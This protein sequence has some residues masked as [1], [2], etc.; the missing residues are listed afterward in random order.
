AADMKGPVAA[1]MDVFVAEAHSHVGLLLTCDEESGG[2][3]GTQHVLRS[4][5]W[6]P[7]V[8]LLPDGGASMRLV[9]QQKGLLRLKL[10]AV[11]RSVH[12]ARPWQ[13]INAL[14]RAFRGYQ[15]MRRAYPPPREEADERISVT[16]TALHSVGNSPN[17]LPDVAEGVLDVRYPGDK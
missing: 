12:A 6:R 17:A 11:G 14:E 16:L 5:A 4:L 9:T 8:V 13:G 2:A 15:S 3:H 1:L 10:T 7:E